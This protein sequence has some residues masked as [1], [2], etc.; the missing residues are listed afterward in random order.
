MT[1]T[2]MILP[3]RDP[4]R[5]RM[6]RVPGDYEEHEAFRHVTGLIA[7]VEE[8]NPDYDWSEIE[9]TLTDHGFETVGFVLGPALD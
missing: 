3:A 9:A 2:L 1:E 5:I 6:V 8:A 7:A 4:H